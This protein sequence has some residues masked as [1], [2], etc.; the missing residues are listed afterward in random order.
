[1]KVWR[2]VTVSRVCGSTVC[3]GGRQKTSE[4]NGIGYTRREGGQFFCEQAP[5]IGQE[6]SSFFT[7]E[8]FS[9][10]AVCPRV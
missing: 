3:S 4:V 5:I 10:Q 1:M 9:L 2:P 7:L 8:V 6:T